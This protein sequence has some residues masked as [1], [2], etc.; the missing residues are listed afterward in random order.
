ME[1]WRHQLM[2]STSSLHAS[3]TVISQK[4]ERSVKRL[5][6]QNLGPVRPAITLTVDQGRKQFKLTN[7]RKAV[8]LAGVRPRVLK[9]CAGSCTFSSCCH[10]L[11]PLYLHHGNPPACSQKHQW[12]VPE[13]LQACCTHLPAGE[14]VWE[15]GSGT[16]KAVDAG[17]SW[18]SAVYLPGQDRCGRC[19]AVHVFTRCISTWREQAV[20]SA[21][22]S[23]TSQVP[24][25]PSSPIL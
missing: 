12:A 14:G 24:S 9:D 22:C 16:A 23:S 2:G 7:A 15:S 8:G 25:T 18:P 3:T 20:Q 13:Q 1:R 11:P 4:K 6:Q 21:L 5:Q 19:T 17:D 10:R